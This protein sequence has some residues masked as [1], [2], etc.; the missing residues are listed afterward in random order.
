[1]GYLTDLF[2]EALVYP[3][4]NIVTLIILG[5]LLT[6]SKFPNVLS[7][8]G[9]DV[10]FQLIII[11]ALI[12]FIVSLFMDGYSLAVIKDAV[13]FNV[14]MPA[15]DI[16]KNFI[17]GV[18]VWVLKIL[19]YIIPTIITIFVALLTG[20]V[21]AI[22]NIFRFIGE[23]QELLSNLNTPAELINAIPQEYIA[24]FL[25]SLF[26][27]AIVAIILYIIFGLLY[28]I[29]L[30]RLAKYDSFNEGINF[31]AIINDIKAIGLGT[32]ILWY[33]ILFL[34]IFAISIVMGLIAAIPYIGIILLNLLFAPF[35]FLLVNRSLGLLYTKAEGYNG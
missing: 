20:G 6:V 27:T 1:M 24:A 5:V 17:D 21:D 10:D 15:F 26:I 32:Y 2:K 29:G 7:S 28:N 31:K 12:S 35:I 19:Y 9:V 33:I 11:F 3:L 14:S 30:C 34:I 18:K 4:S 8:F 23:N 13:D 25:T 16:M 22:L